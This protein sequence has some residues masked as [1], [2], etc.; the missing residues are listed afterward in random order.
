MP[1]RAPR[2]SDKPPTPEEFNQLRETAGWG[3][4]L[5]IRNA[6]TALSNSLFCVSVYSGK[7]LVAMGR[8]IGDGGYAFLIQEIIVLDE[9]QGRGIGTHIVTRLLERIDAIGLERA[10]VLLMSSLNHEGF[11]ERFGFQRR[12]NE[13]RGAGMSLLRQ[14]VQ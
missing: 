8:V 3:P 9:F 4:I 5:P 14:R 13:Q 7:Q 12:P 2:Y 11:Y 6:A 1:S 10:Y